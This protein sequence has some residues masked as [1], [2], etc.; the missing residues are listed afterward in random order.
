M[1][2]EQISGIVETIIYRN[3][4][5][6]YTVLE[7]ALED[8]L[9]TAVCYA[10]LLGE[11]EHVRMEGSWTRHAEYGEQFKA[12]RC[13]VL[14]PETQEQMQRFLASGLIRGCGPVTA[15][16]IVDAFG[17][18]TAQVME[19]APHRLCEIPGIG[20]LTA[21]KIAKSYQEN[22][23][24]RKVVAGLSEYGITVSQALRIAA[25][26]GD[27]A[28]EKVRQNP[29]RLASDIFRIGFKTADAIA[30]KMG[31]E[32]D[33][34]FRIS[35]AVRYLL[36][37]AGEEGHTYLPA[38]ELVEKTAQGIG[39]AQEL[40]QKETARM[41]AM[42]EV[43]LEKGDQEPV[44][45]KTYYQ[46]ETESARRLLQA[47][48]AETRP[49]RVDVERSIQSM[50]HEM[51][52]LLADQQIQAIRTASGNPVS[53]IT[54]G[55][56]T[57]K[58]TILKF[59][60]GIFERAGV[61]YELCAPTG[62]AAKR[63][64]EATKRPA[65]TIHRL[66]EYGQSEEGGMPRFLKDEEHP[67]TCGA[68]IIDEMSMVDILLMMR[69]MRAIRPGTRLVMIGDADQLPS[70]GPGNV[71]RDIIK[72]RVIPTVALDTVFRQGEG[73]AI[74]AN[75]QLI[76]LGQ[77]PK[78]EPE[79]GFSIL[80]A[81]DAAA[82]WQALAGIVKQE[83]VQVIVPMKK[84]EVGVNSLNAKL[85]QMLN[86]KRLGRKEY[87]HNGRILR[88]GDRVM[89]IK[90]D[91]RME[92]TKDQG[93]RVEEG[94][95]VFNGDMGVIESIQTDQKCLTVLFDD[96][97]R[98]EYSFLQLDEL[99]LAYAISIHKSQGSEFPSVAILI[100]GGPP[101]L[102]TRNLLYTAVTRAK[103]KVYL[104]GR[105]EAVARMVTN[106]LTKK[107][108]SGFQRFLEEKDDED[109]KMV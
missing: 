107:R 43:I 41:C 79:N 30:K 36:Q 5:N 80:K 40:V 74:S 48:H 69:L 108:Y 2:Q 12:T 1:A 49:L 106:N 42:G 71:L 45:L 10:P 23:H 99:E 59:L 8:A 98:S 34:P 104:I 97:R 13:M 22:M 84:G 92:W 31:F 65:R 91:Y 96:D 3:E 82:A 61:E 100:L 21:E 29:Y 15:K 86:P 87:E 19:Y 103:S 93:A 44:Y 6:G 57:G 72:S 39:V 77:M 90:N 78:A 56:G 105:A 89:Q 58:T 52:I 62:R 63:M 54:G 9:I 53:I 55:P 85:Q 4:A 35:A 24:L 33:S 95:G 46:A 51:G 11:G 26:Y 25:E 50:Q 64:E 102:Y 47:A 70:V 16:A 37:L 76:H 94:L 83:D 7:L 109:C 88:T 32:E 81:E 68:V 28:V 73:S 67:L 27:M 17:E 18:D 75:A 101:M 66:L 20:Q 38:K 14:P 60:I